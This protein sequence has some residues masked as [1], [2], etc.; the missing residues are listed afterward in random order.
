MVVFSLIFGRLGHVPSDGLPYPLFSLGGLV[1]WSFFSNG[2][3]LGSNSLVSNVALLT[4]VYF[5]RILVPTATVVAGLV[6]LAI[7]SV[8]L[9]V[10]M[11]F[12]GRT[13][14][15]QVFLVPIILVMAILTTVGVSVGLGAMNV[16]YR[17]VRYVVPFLAQLWLFATPVAYPASVLHQPW[18]TLIGLNPMAGVVEGFRWC[19]IGGD[20]NPL[21]IVAVSAVSSIVFFLVGVGY[22]ARVER[23]F[24]DVA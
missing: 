5:P 14:P 20:H 10:V 17:D 8:V 15:L 2:L 19:V 4:K 23:G 13:P 3:M 24:A 16:R 18:R 7:A 1:I 11:L 9:V 21:G 22:F 6:D 12:Y